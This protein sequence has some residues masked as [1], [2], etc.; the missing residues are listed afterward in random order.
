MRLRE[1]M[2]RVL[3]G[4]VSPVFF[5]GSLLRGARIFHPDGVVYRAEVQ[6]LANAGELGELAN[7]LAGPALVR[8]SGG[9]WRARDGARERLP[10]ILGVAVRLR[11]STAVV[12][13]AAPGDQDLL[14]ESSRTLWRLPI[15]LIT[16]D[17]RDYLANTYWGMLPFDIEGV[18]K[19]K[20][21]L[22]PAPSAK[23]TGQDRLERLDNAVAAGTAVLRLEVR[24][25]G[26]PW[27][28]VAD[29]VLLERVPVDQ[30]RLRF[31]PF[32]T[33]KGIVPRGLIQA[34]RSPVYTASQL[35]RGG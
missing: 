14:F 25:R 23:A 33:G 4:V 21:R 9:L 5:V 35:G 26:E 34:M 2:G 30:S 17:T 19:A 10:D 16:T 1:I 7:R 11:S 28:A 6:P 13:E 20:L 31:Q 18:G 27:T 32:R 29:V 12:A 22:V 3:G 15:A 8:L 24:R